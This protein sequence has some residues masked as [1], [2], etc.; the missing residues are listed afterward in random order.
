MKR[1]IRGNLADRV[2]GGGLLEGLTFLADAVGRGRNPLLAFGLGAI[3]GGAAQANHRLA[4]R[5]AAS[6]DNPRLAKL[7]VDLLDPLTRSAS[8]EGGLAAAQPRPLFPR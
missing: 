5:G 8:E 3:A 4:A 2:I 6:V 1:I 7:A